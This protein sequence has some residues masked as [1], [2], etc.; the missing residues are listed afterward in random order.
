MHSNCT[1]LNTLICNVKSILCTITVF[2]IQPKLSRLETHP[3][4]ITCLGIS[5]EGWLVCTCSE[6]EVLLSKWDSMLSKRNTFFFSISTCLSIYKPFVKIIQF[7]IHFFLIYVFTDTF[8]S[9]KIAVD[10]GKIHSCAVSIKKNLVFTSLAKSNEILVIKCTGAT[11]IVI[12]FF[13]IS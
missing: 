4:L 8:S 10:L 5:N 9:N 12:F 13:T 2:F 11:K 6:S 1:L 7:L 3:T